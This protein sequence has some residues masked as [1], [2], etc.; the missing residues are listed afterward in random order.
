MKSSFNKKLAEELNKRDFLTTKEIYSLFPDMNTS[1]VSWHLNKM[2]K[3]AA[4]EQVSHGVWRLKNAVC[5]SFPEERLLRLQSLSRTAYSLLKDAGYFFYLSGL[6]ALNGSGLDV[7]GSFP[8]IVCVEK[9]RVNDTRML[10]MRESDFAVTE[11]DTML[12]GD[13]S[14]RDKI[15]YIVLE[16]KAKELSQDNFAI[17][18]KAFVDLYWAITRLDYPVEITNLPGIL[19]LIQPN[20]YRFRLA[21]K[22]RHLSDELNFLVRYDRSFIKAFASYLSLPMR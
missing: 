8:V 18:E 10:L 14:L 15:R 22:D 1:T 20:A 5:S 6:D 2:S 11:N 9:N 12:S 7:N 13:I 19:N 21:T 17:A 4:I 3:Q 16:T